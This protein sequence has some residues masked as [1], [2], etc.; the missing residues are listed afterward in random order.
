M[1]LRRRLL[2]IFA[3]LAVVVL[4]IVVFALWMQAGRLKAHG[5][6]LSAAL[7]PLLQAGI[8]AGFGAAA[9]TAVVWFLCD[10]H[11][12]RPIEG[13]TG[14]LRT[15]RKP[16][17]GMAPWL[18]ELV[19][20]A[21]D[22]ADA[23]SRADAALTE[24]L[25]AHA[26]EVSRE[27][28]TLEA[29]LA[30]FGAG[31]VMTDAGGRVVFYNSSAA[32]LLPGLALDRPLGRH[33]LPGAI[34]AAASRLGAGAEATD[35]T[36]LSKTGQRLMCRMRR[37]EDGTLLILRDHPP[38]R[39]APRAALEALRRHS[40]T[41]I[42]MLEALDGPIPPALVQAIRQEG[43]GLAV[44]TR[45]LS[46]EMAGQAPSV[47][48]GLDE[49]TA[50]LTLA[51]DVPQLSVFAEAGPVNALL[52]LLD[53]NLRAEGR[54]PLVSICREDGAELSLQLSWSGEALAMD[55]L[56]TWLEEAPDPG[57]PELSGADI[58]ATHGTGIWPRAE[59]ATACLVLPLRVA[60]GQRDTA[61]VIY[62]F[63]L[64]TR[65]AASTRLADLTCV[66]F[67]TETTGL[68]P[69]DRIVQIAGLRIARGRLTGE[70]FETLVNPDRAIPASATAIHG[71]TDEMVRDAPDMSAALTA[72]HHFAEDA[73]LVAHN[74]P[75]DMG[76]LR[77]ASAETGAWFD[78]RV[79][80]TVLLS[81][82]IWGSGVS[83]K[84]EDLAERLSIAIPDGARHT[85]MGDTIV[86]A[87]AFTQMIPALEA[88]GITRL[89]DV[90]T[91][92]RRH[93]RLIRDANQSSI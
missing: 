56:E 76:L 32:R 18:G 47:R 78:N 93:R 77:A 8:V 42:P 43:Q 27:K 82:M 22:A 23:R 65:G 35:L 11:F 85:A 13:L 10:Q 90:I 68:E 37:I 70:R 53:E 58:L 73:V 59:G 5:V 19:A 91:E 38:D 26:V 24:A 50:G 51:D 69:S 3:A 31:A 57:Q 87:E 33:F 14:N 7:D 80:D 86:T 2:L 9:A 88:K 29:I 61:G 45:R 21:G 16:A 25:D 44:A 63:A 83:H 67:D 92:A 60:T 6:P 41:L 15:G 62:D 54:A 4:V 52:R 48:A 46:E 40:A 1:K 30:D 84:L 71:I 17:P 72:F 12:A 66:V 64:A 36:C 34:E 49:L 89:E 39:P 55:R 28:E 81:A 75:F 20:A 79:M 74:A